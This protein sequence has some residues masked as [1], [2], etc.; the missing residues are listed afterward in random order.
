MVGLS[1]GD[2]PMKTFHT[3]QGMISQVMR[4]A[5]KTS[6][7]PICSWISSIPN[8]LLRGARAKSKQP[9]N[10]ETKSSPHWPKKLGGGNSNIFYSH[11]YLGKIPILTNI[12]QMGWFNHQLEKT[13]T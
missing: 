10:N 3:L 6:K 12:F 9:K 2:T 8:Q 5:A 11:P 1:L 13:S 4:P 7:N